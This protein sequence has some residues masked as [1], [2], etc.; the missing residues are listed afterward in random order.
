MDE[1]LQNM[2]QSNCFKEEY[3]QL[4]T[5]LP[6]SLTTKEIYSAADKNKK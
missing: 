4:S 3:W 1:S 2:I 6:C 5:M